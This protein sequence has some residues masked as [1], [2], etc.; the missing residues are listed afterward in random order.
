MRRAFWCPNLEFGAVPRP[1]LV[2]GGGGGIIRQLE[3]VSIGWRPVAAGV[4]VWSWSFAPP[5]PLVLPRM[6]V[7]LGVLVVFSVVQWPVPLAAPL[8]INGHESAGL[9][10]PCRWWW[11]VADDGGHRLAMGCSSRWRPFFG[12]SIGLCGSGGSLRSGGCDVCCGPT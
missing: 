8:T 7:V 1:E 3:V 10:V 6:V 4:V 5:S 2:G 12:S 11:F 9:A